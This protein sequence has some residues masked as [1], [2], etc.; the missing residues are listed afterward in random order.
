MNLKSVA[1]FLR[2]VVLY[3]SSL[4]GGWVLS[5]L[6]YQ[7]H[8]VPPFRPNIEVY[9]LFENQNSNQLFYFDKSDGSHCQRSAIYEQKQNILNQTVTEV[10]PTNDS[11]CSDDTDMRLNSNS[12]VQFEIQGDELHLF[13]Q[14]G[15]DP[16]QYVFKKMY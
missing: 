15:E 10:D 12:E 13:L 7:G 2:A 4:I 8:Q 5:F 1:I 6:I 11:F 16:I 14:I 3:M 9:Y